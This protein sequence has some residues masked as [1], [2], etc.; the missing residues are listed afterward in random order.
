M[1]GCSIVFTI[2]AAFLGRRFQPR[3]GTYNATL[4]AA[5]VFIVAICI[6][7]AL[8]PS[9]GRLA[10]NKANA[11]SIGYGNSATETPLPVKD[12]NGNIV[13]PGF[14]ADVL[15]KFRFYSVIAQLIIWTAIGLI[16]STLV[17]RVV[18]KEKPTP[19]DPMPVERVPVSVLS[20]N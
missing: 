2:L 9:L 13:H 17:D 8:L 19:A 12:F 18:G 10:A 6:V 20:A 4:I 3:F 11:H 5:G 15:W 1:V 7:M 16:F 14:P